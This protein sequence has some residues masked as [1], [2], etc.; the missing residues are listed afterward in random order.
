M[1]LFKG[2]DATLLSM[3]VNGFAHPGLEQVW[4]FFHRIDHGGELGI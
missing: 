3:E 4:N 1:S 2:E